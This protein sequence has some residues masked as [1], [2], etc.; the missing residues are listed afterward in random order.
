MLWASAPPLKRMAPC[1]AGI[2]ACFACF[3]L[4][5]FR[6]PRMGAVAALLWLFGAAG[7]SLTYLLSFAFS[8]RASQQHVNLLPTIHLHASSVA[9]CQAPSH[10]R[11]P[12]CVRMHV[13]NMA[14]FACHSKLVCSVRAARSR[15]CGTSR[16]P[17][18][19]CCMFSG[20]GTG[21]TTHP[22]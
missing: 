5:Q 17:V 6:G 10:K 12:L 1:R 3:D 18:C 19:S 16:S 9:L 13:R 15:E 7:L 11:P 22:Q 4:P 20:R 21:I 2:I 14:A 8:V